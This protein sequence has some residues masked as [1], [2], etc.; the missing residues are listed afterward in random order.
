MSVIVVAPDSFKGSA[1]AVAVASAVADGWR[2]VRPDDELVLAPMADGGEGTLDA[3]AAAVPGAVRNR[4]RVHGPDGGPVDAS[5][6]ELPDGTAVVE[7][8]DASGLGRMRELA[9]FDAHTVGFGQAIAAALDAG[10]SAL[11][12][13]IG[14][15]ASTDGGAG[16]LTALGARLLGADG[17][18]I[19]TGNSGLSALDRVNLAHLRPLP[20]GGAR[21]LSD[22][23]SP[24]LGPSGAAAVFGP[25]KGATPSDIPLLE[26][27]LRRLADAMAAARPVSPNEHGAG[28]AGGTGFALLAWGAR[29]A[30]GAAAVGEALGL[31][32]LVTRADAVITGEGRYDRQSAA[33]KVP[34]YVARLAQSP[35]IPSLLVAG[36]IDAP[37]D[38][39]ADAVAIADLAGSREAAMADP[40]HW[41]F[42][43]G[44]AL[45]LRYRS[46]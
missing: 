6:L 40:L 19:P 10:A 38:G 15:S 4:V 20:P 41:I 25:Q 22:V 29:M 2:S 3:F 33:G 30:P 31:P 24:L 43:G 28:A 34:E 35:G 14:G 8:A 11:L 16:A 36:S 26:D 21:I 44:A 46:E 37:T 7:L 18:E 42:A 23:T 45:A 1:S 32:A 5:W 27:G 17:Q 39:F 9:P 12:L 13:A